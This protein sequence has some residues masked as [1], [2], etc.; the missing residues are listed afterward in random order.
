VSSSL[1]PASTAREAAVHNT[2]LVKR[3]YA[4]RR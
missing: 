3:G 4:F 1:G 2:P